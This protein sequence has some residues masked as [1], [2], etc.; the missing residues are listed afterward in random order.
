MAPV[1][2][3]IGLSSFLMTIN[4]WKVNL[5]LSL[6]Y[7]TLDYPDNAMHF[8]LNGQAHQQIEF[9]IVNIENSYRRKASKTKTF[10][11]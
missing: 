3:S 4:P 6:F 2:A 11:M 1:D 8:L 5:L 10:Q 9:F 7:G